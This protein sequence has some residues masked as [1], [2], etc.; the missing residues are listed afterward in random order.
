MD[1]EATRSTTSQPVHTQGDDMYTVHILWGNT[2]ATHTA[3]SL[4]DAKE[5]LY[6]YP[7]GTSEGFFGKVTNL[8]GQRVAVRHW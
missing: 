8:F 3:W 6:K 2:A 1:S 5:W 7:K 4:A